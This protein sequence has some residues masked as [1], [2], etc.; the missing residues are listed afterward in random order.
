MIEN[1]V[2]AAIG[3]KLVNGKIRPKY[4]KSAIL[5]I[6]F[7]ILLLTGFI[8]AFIYGLLNGDVEFVIIPALGI[9]SVIYLLLISPYTQNSSD[10]YI[11]FQNENTLA[12]FRLFYKQ[13]LV[14]IQYKVDSVGKIA[15]ANNG[16]KLSCISYADGTNMSNFVKYKIINYFSKWLNDNQLLSKEVTTTL[17]QL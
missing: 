12:G 15:F 10:Y 4:G 7:F 11:E 9:A 2:G 16:S 6:G 13:K 8:I 5:G 14:Y 3:T 1:I 17:E